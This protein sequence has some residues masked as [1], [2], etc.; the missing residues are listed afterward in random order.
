MES[1]AMGMVVINQESVNRS[2]ITSFWVLG[3][4]IY[5][6]IIGQAVLSVCNFSF[7]ESRLGMEKKSYESDSSCPRR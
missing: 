1:R 4:E 2:Q 5:T 7:V 3:D 6:Q